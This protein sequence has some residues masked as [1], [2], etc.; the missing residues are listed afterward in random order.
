MTTHPLECVKHAKSAGQHMYF[1]CKVASLLA[2]SRFFRVSPTKVPEQCQH[3]GARMAGCS[4][5]IAAATRHLCDGMVYGG[6]NMQISGR[7]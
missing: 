2:Y 5:N 3:D 6:A 4:V 7:L 1:C